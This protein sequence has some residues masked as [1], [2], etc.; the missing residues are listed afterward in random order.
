MNDRNLLLSYN[1]LALFNFDSNLIE[2]NGAAAL[3][4]KLDNSSQEFSQD[5]SS[6]VGFTFDSNKSEF[7]AGKLQQKYVLPENCSCFATFT[8]STAM[9]KVDDSTSLAPTASNAFVADGALQFAAISNQ[10][11]TWLPPQSIKDSPNNLSIYFEISFNYNG[12]GTQSQGMTIFS[13]SKLSSSF[14][15]LSLSHQAHNAGAPLY[16]QA[17]DGSG[18]SI[19]YINQPFA[20][21]KDQVYLFCIRLYNGTLTLEVDGDVIGTLSMAG[22]VRT[23]DIGHLTLGASAPYFSFFKIHTFAYYAGQATL[24]NMDFFSDYNY[25]ENKVDCPSFDYSALGNIQGWESLAATL[26]GNVRFIHNGL[27]HNGTSWISSDGSYSQANTLAEAQSAITSLPAADSIIPSIVFSNSSTQQSID[28][29]RLFYTGQKYCDSN[30]SIEVLTGKYLD[31]IGEFTVDSTET[32]SAYLLFIM[33]V[34]SQLYYYDGA[35]WVKSDGTNNEANTIAEINANLSSFDFGLGKVFKLKVLLIS[36][37]GIGTPL[38]ETIDMTYD[39]AANPA[40]PT[41]CKMYGFIIDNSGN[42]IEGANIEFDSAD[43]Y[44]GANLVTRSIKSVSDVNG[45][46][47][48]DLIRGVTISQTVVYTQNGINEEYNDSFLVPNLDDAPIYE[49]VV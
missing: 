6:D 46:Y 12:D 21:V 17:I 41:V 19:G 34:N 10:K 28:L 30:P 1:S 3:L 26:T 42:P 23:S 38:L 7:S 47:E 9:S 13:T 2:S 16:L 49:N 11:A 44:S 14:N 27:Y 25:S 20:C 32:A 4:K 48:A 37:D 31:G 36:T 33:N 15:L 8:N 18:V 40:Y 39:F 29:Y 45:Y 22:K 35:D 5:F 43:F 24:T